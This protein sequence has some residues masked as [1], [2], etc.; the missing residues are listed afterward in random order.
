MAFATALASPAVSAQSAPPAA[1]WPQHARDAQRTAYSPQQVDPP[2]C[3]AW[4]WYEVPIASRAQPVVVD[5][6]LFVGG[7]D[8]VVYARN[9]STGAPLWRYAT[10]GPVR[11]SLAVWRDVVTGSSH[12]G[13]TYAL[14]A[15]DGGVRWRAAT[16]AS[17]TAPLVDTGRNVVYVGSTDG[18]L[19]ALS[20]ASGATVWQVN[21][22][23]PILTSP[24]LSLDGALLFIGA[25]SIEA[26]AIEAATGALRWRRAV[27]GQ[28]LGDRYPVVAGGA[29]IYRSQPLYFFHDLLHEGDD[30][31]DQ[32]G[33]VS[34]DWAADWTAIKPHIVTYLTA[35]P[36]KQSLFVLNAADG[37]SR[38]VAPVL[39][40]FG[41]NDTPSPPV[42]RGAEIY[43]AYR[44]RRGIQT[45]SNI[46]VHVTS[47]YDAELGRF[48]L[49]TS[50]IAGLRQSNYPA[51][52]SEFRLTSDEPSII[53]MGGDILWVDNWERAGGINVATGAL[54]HAG[55]VSND[56][57]ECSAQ[58][59]PGTTQPFFPLS[60]TGQA[61]PFPAPRV[62]EGHQ[63]GGI[64]IAN[65]MV[66]W[67]VIEG[68]IAALSHRGGPSCP[69]PA[70]WT[71]PEAP[72]TPVAA[73]PSSD[74]PLSDYVSIDLTRPSASPAP[75]LLAR[76]RAEVAALTS[77][78]GHATPFYV[79]R[80]FSK[81]FLWPYNSTAA[82]LAA[83]SYNGHGSVYWHDP[84]ELLYS[85]ALAYPYL[86]LAQQGAV[87]EYVE[88]EIARYPPLENLPYEG[89]WLR[90]G[91][92]R[93][94]YAV[95][96][97]DALNPW[98][99]PATHISA[100]YA[101]WLWS[102]NT[103]DWSYAEQRWSN[104]SALFNARRGSML[105]YGDIAGGIGYSRLAA[106]LGDRE[107]AEAG[108]QA[109]VAA[110][111]AGLDFEAF[112][113]RAESAYLD[114]R[115]VASGW[116]APVFYGLTPEV[117]W[118]L[119]EKTGGSAL[120]Y[121]A[122]K[123][124]GNGARWWYLTKGGAHAELGE[125]SY[126]APSTAWSHFLAHAYIG[127]VSQDQLRRWLDRPWARGDLYSIQKLVA[128]IQAY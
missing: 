14:G 12:D 21:V 11:H 94:P 121:L 22:N 123:E 43:T 117:G 104:A 19:S 1:D 24:A 53:S 126:L 25:E 33:P 44:A 6:R 98:P 125:S 89:A 105:Y 17:A 79:Q 120:A 88:G 83:I 10:D 101:L 70:V 28:S 23:R 80:G 8:G 34:S 72:T 45:D 64:V 55:A 73:P 100:L 127:R 71:S 26:I 93:E 74:R 5:G 107:A 68:G 115:D 91:T 51:Y 58:C 82:G 116:S 20:L 36:A 96:F 13:Y 67:R 59:G 60:G 84:G 40:A 103:N 63:R 102:Q 61:Y 16:G 57:P 46:A 18:R 9:A 15:A 56:W 62:T 41:N 119:R 108:S 31:M 81:A 7:M 114:P 124:H 77:M 85:L 42:V 122:S 37:V 118:Y 49:T 32:A 65:N 76:L 3:Y 48:N 66:Y 113:R 128:T 52:H 109:A 90:Q 111:Q 39:Y 99:P 38:G 92:P 2:Y 50:D 106:H 29:V 95:P 30:V 86:D 112:R 27:S 110:M 54:V 78:G 47:R 97:R 75:D 4:K 69:T 87:R 35:N